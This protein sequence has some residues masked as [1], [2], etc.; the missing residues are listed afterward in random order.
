MLRQLSRTKWPQLRHIYMVSLQVYQLHGLPSS[1][2]SHF[3]PHL[4]I[5]NHQAHY[6]PTQQQQQQVLLSKPYAPVYTTS[7]GKVQGHVPPPSYTAQMAVIAGIQRD[8]FQADLQAATEVLNPSHASEGLLARNALSQPPQP[9][10]SAASQVRTHTSDAA[11]M[12]INS[13]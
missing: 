6:R 4:A 11:Q 2:L 7:P 9:P 10:V 12:D 13:D 5:S 1:P 3:E 8:C